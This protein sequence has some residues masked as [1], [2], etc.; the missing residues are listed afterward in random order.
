MKYTPSNVSESNRAYAL[1]AEYLPIIAQGMN[2]DVNI[3][4]N[5][6]G[7][8]NLVR[9]ANNKLVNATGYY[10]LARS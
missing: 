10:A 3:N 4:Q 1:L 8:Y 6:M 7:T 2:V 9:N 5:E